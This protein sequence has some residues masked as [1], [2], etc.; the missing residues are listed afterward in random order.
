MKGRMFVVNSQTLISTQSTMIASIF[1][2][3]PN[4]EK[5]LSTISDIMADM[6]QIEIGDYI[7]LWETSSEAQ[8]S[9]IHGVYRAISKPYY[10]CADANDTAPFKIHIEKAYD[11]ENPIDEYDVLNCPYIKSSMWTIIGKKVKGKSRGTSPL[12][13]DEIKNLITL[14]IGK[15]PNYSYV[16]FDATRVLNVPTELK[17]D[18]KKEQT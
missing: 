3:Q 2:P 9:R 6:L 16:E 5:W 1:A 10:E 14:L 18:Y 12:S 11:F 13:Q 8:K 7:F 4:G 15:N 17:I